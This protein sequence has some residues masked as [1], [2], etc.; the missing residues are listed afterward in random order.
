MAV[1]TWYSV[2]TGAGSVPWAAL[3]VAPAV[4]ASCLLAAATALPLLGRSVRPGELRYV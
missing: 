2:V 4:Y 3:L 1:G